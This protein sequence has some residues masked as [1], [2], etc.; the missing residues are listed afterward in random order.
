[1]NRTIAERARC[2]RLNAGLPKMFW[3]EA[4]S[5]AVFV[6][7]RSPSIALNGKVAEEV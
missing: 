7:N 4:V 3:A 1:M 2:I 6:I 5:M